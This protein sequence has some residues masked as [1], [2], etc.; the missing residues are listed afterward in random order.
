MRIFWEVDV[1]PVSSSS[2]TQKRLTCESFF[3]LYSL[4]RCSRIASDEENVNK[5][6]CGVRLRDFCDG[7]LNYTGCETSRSET[8]HWTGTTEGTWNVLRTLREVDAISAMANSTTQNDSQCESFFIYSVNYISQIIH[9]V[10]DFWA[11]WEVIWEAKLH[12]AKFWACDGKVK[13]TFAILFY[14]KIFYHY[15]VYIIMI[16]LNFI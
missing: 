9:T 15:N 4:I 7:E 2:T 1:G 16:F 13:Q 8:D 11:V 5:L 12:S 10:N 3:Y 14:I 6:L